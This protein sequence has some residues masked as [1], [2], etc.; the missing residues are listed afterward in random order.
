MEGCKKFRFE[1]EG[2]REKWKDEAESENYEEE[3]K[4]LRKRLQKMEARWVEKQEKEINREIEYMNEFQSKEKILLKRYEQLEQRYSGLVWECD[5]L[6]SEK[7]GLLKKI[8]E[9]EEEKTIFLEERESKING[10][11]EITNMCREVEGKLK[12]AK[13]DSKRLNLSYKKK[14][15]VLE[16]LLAQLISRKQEAEENYTKNKENTVKASKSPCKSGRMTRRSSV[17]KA[18]KVA[19][20]IADLEKSHLHYKQ[21]YSVLQS[22]KGAPFGELNHIFDLLKLNEKK[23]KKAKRLQKA[24]L[25]E[26]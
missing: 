13:E 18:S 22:A 3:N 23:L 24:L 14:I 16:A 8:K 19:S 9:L 25:K 2:K 15:V 11:Y 17:N 4:E 21:K 5:A 26:L 20:L 6:Q 12:A 10:F 7:S 1:K